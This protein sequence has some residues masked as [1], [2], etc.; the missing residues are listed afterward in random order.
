MKIKRAWLFAILGVA[1]TFSCVEKKGFDQ[2]VTNDKPSAPEQSAQMTDTNKAEALLALLE[3]K[4]W[5]LSRREARLDSLE[6]ALAEQERQ[7]REQQMSLGSFR[8]TANLILI[9]GIILMAFSILLVLVRRKQKPS[10]IETEIEAA[11][12]IHKNDPGQQPAPLEQQESPSPS[13]HTK[14]PSQKRQSAK[15]KESSGKQ[16]LNPDAS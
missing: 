2:D 1:I 15:A 5:E 3:Q 7:L 8:H 16:P 6:R 9:A 4:A 12:R 10:T 14:E 13:D 11:Q